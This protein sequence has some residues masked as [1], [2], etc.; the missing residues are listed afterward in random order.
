MEAR[1]WEA[2]FLRVKGELLLTADDSDLSRAESCFTQ[3][4]EIARLQKSK[5]F[6]LRAANSL[7]KMWINSG[8]ARPAF[9]LV[10][11]LYGWFTEGFDTEILK[12]SAAL[13]EQ[14]D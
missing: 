10:A 4:I 12:E 8:K 1:W 5:A 2:E 7:A 14:L 13:L 11:P 9:D 3:A 6:E